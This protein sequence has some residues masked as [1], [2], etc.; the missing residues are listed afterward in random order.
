MNTLNTSPSPSVAASTIETA[1]PHAR[2]SRARWNSLMWAMMLAP[3]AAVVLARVLFVG[4]VVGPATA[5]ADSTPPAIPVLPGDASASRS[6]LDEAVS[7]SER[8]AQASGTQAV[9]L[10]WATGPAELSQFLTDRQA[11]PVTPIEAPKI[12]RPDIA[13]TSIML[14]RG[15]RIA[16]VQ[17]KVRREGDSP[18]PGWTITQINPDAG[19]ITL[20]HNTGPSENFS[21]SNRSPR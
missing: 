13:L 7:A 3:A 5:Y 15:E 11:A 16:V 21:L 4:Q 9:R 6:K 1:V 19:T 17:G 10:R 20:T 12:A 8:I 14:T 18:I 2:V